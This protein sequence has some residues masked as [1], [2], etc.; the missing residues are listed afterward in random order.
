VEPL[1][2]SFPEVAD[3]LER[4]RSD[5]EVAETFP[6]GLVDHLLMHLREQFRANP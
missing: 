4:H 1:P 2:L 5:L 3:V 6:P